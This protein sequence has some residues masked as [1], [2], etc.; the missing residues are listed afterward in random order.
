M[1]DLFRL[2]KNFVVYKVLSVP[3]TDTEQTIVF[4]YNLQLTTDFL[5]WVPSQN[6][7]VTTCPLIPT[8]ETLGV[9]GLRVNKLFACL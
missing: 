3:V 9:D 5:L 4:N 7:T 2:L 6:I 8:V 1:L